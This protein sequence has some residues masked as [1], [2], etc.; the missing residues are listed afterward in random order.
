MDHRAQSPWPNCSPAS[1]CH[2]CGSTADVRPPLAARLGTPRTAWAKPRRRVGTDFVHACHSSV[3]R[4]SDRSFRE[5]RVMSIRCVGSGYIVRADGIFLDPSRYAIHAVVA[6]ADA[7]SEKERARLGPEAQ[8][9][10]ML[11]IV[12][13]SHR[14]RTR[15]AR[16]VYVAVEGDCELDGFFR[17][18][19][20]QIPREILA[21][22]KSTGTTS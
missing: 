7:V 1:T 14:G 8:I 12:A 4:A 2:R 15:G 10:L 9:D 11:A 20:D 13:E 17:V 19:A 5:G 3:T 6:Y 21:Q 22:V 16:A 18:Q